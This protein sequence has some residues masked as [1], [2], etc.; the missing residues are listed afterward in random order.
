MSHAFKPPVQFSAR[1]LELTH[2]IGKQ[3]ADAIRLRRNL[4]RLGLTDEQIKIAVYLKVE[5]VAS[6]KKTPES[7]TDVHR[8]PH[9]P[10][11][12]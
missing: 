3:L 9:Q 7:V 6:A 4:V 5:P 8:T 1:E 2:A 11:A 10:G 12:R